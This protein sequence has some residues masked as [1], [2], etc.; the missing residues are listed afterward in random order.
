MKPNKNLEPI[1]TI[2][3]E[4]AKNI[5]QRRKLANELRIYAKY[6]LS[7]RKLGVIVDNTSYIYEISNKFQELEKVHTI[8]CRMYYNI[9]MKGK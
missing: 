1:K 7:K 4:I 5:I 2:R 8:L 3:S 9:I 6:T